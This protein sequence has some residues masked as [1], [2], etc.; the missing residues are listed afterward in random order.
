MFGCF[1]YWS[2]TISLK[3]LTGPQGSSMLKLLEF[4]D[5]PHMKVVRLSALAPAVFTPMKHS[6]YSFLLEVDSTP[7]P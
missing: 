7:E 4:P 2:K 6:K 5:N 1:D 3:A